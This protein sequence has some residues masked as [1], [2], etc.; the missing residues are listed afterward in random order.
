MDD[1]ETWAAINNG[2]PRQFIPLSLVAVPTTPTT[3]YA[4][5]GLGVFKSTDAGASWKE[6]AIAGPAAVVAFNPQD[7]S[8]VYAGVNDPN[9]A[10]VAKLNST[11]S[12]LLYCTYLGGRGADHA[13]AIA[14]DSMGNAYV[15]GTT[16]SNTFT[17]Q[18]A[19]QTEKGEALYT[20]FVTKLNGDG[21]EL[22]FSTYFGGSKDITAGQGIFL[23]PAGDVYVAGW[24][25]SPDIPTRGALQAAFSGGDFDSFLF[26]LGAPRITSASLS[27]KQLFVGGENFNQGA[28]LLINGDEQN[29]RNDD[30]SPS[31]RLI[32]KKAGKRIPS[33]QTARI[34]VR[35]SDATL[36]NEFTFTRAVE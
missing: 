30:A 6:S 19:L 35:N 33:G 10:F 20:T 27:G 5:S 36:S 2:L 8:I 3:L 13:Q 18:R 32:G 26:K 14:I 7:P 34:R 17:T 31:T 23:S 16:F 25:A 11:G 21:S 24:T 4:A 9:D 22:L 15:T 12:A 28:T 1:G 29:T